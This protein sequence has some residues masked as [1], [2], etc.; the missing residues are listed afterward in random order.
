MTSVYMFLPTESKVSI[1]SPY[2]YDRIYC[3]VAKYDGIL[4]VHE[5]CHTRHESVISIDLTLRDN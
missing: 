1:K 2:S 5:I 4:L 3:E